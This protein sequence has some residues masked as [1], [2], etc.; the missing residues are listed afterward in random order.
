MGDRAVATSSI[1]SAPKMPSSPRNIATGTEPVFSTIRGLEENV[2]V[3]I[4]P[5]RNPGTL[6]PWNPGRRRE[7]SLLYP[8][9]VTGSGFDGVRRKKEEYRG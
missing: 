6:E 9:L 4:S 8:R 7:S 5:S 3:P 1:L 2:T